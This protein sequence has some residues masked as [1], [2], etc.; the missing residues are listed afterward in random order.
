MSSIVT[1]IENNKA[2]TIHTLEGEIS[3]ADIITTIEEYYYGEATQ[4][5]IWDYS[6]AQLQN[7]KDESIKAIVKV[8]N[9]YADRRPG[10]RSALV[11]PSDLKFGLGRVYE[12]LAEA[13]N[14]VIVT[15][16]F[17]SLQEAR[18]WLEDPAV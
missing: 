14:S 7:C 10:G 4:D 8:A 13:A 15:K 12:A 9:R 2:L 3:G 18:D 5:V 17:R 11:L 1:H 16:S 6:N